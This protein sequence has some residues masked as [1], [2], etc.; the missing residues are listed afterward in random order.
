[1]NDNDVAFMLTVPIDEERTGSGESLRERRYTLILVDT[2]S[3]A[4]EI[5][6][7]FGRLP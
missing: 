3:D 7:A 6:R 5:L 2:D 4:E 1:V